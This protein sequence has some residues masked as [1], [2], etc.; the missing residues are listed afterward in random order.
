MGIFGPPNV[1]KMKQKRDIEG[2]TKALRHKEV[3]IRH[4]AAS[5]LGELDDPQCADPLIAAL[6]DI[7]EVVR[8]TAASNLTRVNMSVP[9]DVQ[10][11]A[12]AIYAM[13][14]KDDALRCRAVE[15]LQELRDLRGL[16]ALSAALMDTSSDVRK[17]AVTALSKFDVERAMEAITFAKVFDD[18]DRSVRIAFIATLG[19]LAH[20]KAVDFLLAAFLSSSGD[21]EL[22]EKVAFSMGRLARKMP[23]NPIL[24]KFTTTAKQTKKNSQDQSEVMDAVDRLVSIYQQQPQGFIQGQNSPAELEIRR[25][26]QI[27]YDQGGMDLMRSTHA[28]FASK[29]SIP[30]A[31]RNLEHMWDGIGGWQG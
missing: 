9:E 25:I 21:P 5:A 7:D 1:E 24:Q 17:A 8:T 19:E 11:L 6:D 18:K 31:S 26:G 27:L 22:Q 3:T 23:D 10:K 30:G 29:C 28:S 20:P 14:N 2:L 12:N 16:R 13:A 15:Q 4:K